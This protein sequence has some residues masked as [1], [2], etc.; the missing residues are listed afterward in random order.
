VNLALMDVYV[1]EL[2]TLKE[3]TVDR[4]QN[5]FH[6]DWFDRNRS[7][8]MANNLLLMSSVML[9]LCLPNS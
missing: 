6:E 3:N 4:A 2:R 1:V 8:Q 5:L 7:A 9:E